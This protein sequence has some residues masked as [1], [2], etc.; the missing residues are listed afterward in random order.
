MVAGGTDVIMRFFV[1]A[2]EAQ[3]S[4]SFFLW[5]G[6]GDVEGKPFIAA[7]PRSSPLSI[8]G[9]VLILDLGM[10]SRSFPELRPQSLGLKP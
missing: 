6:G 5:A 10:Q 4:L 8:R 1:E 2:I 3:N 9:G 7:A